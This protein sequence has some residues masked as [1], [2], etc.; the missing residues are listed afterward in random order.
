MI[1]LEW[2]K[3]RIEDDLPQEKS[4]DYLIQE[5][6]LLREEMTKSMDE[7]RLLERYSL[8]ATSVLW[9][10]AVSNMNNPPYKLVMWLPLLI[11]SLFSLR[12]LSLH[13]HTR[14]TGQYITMVEKQFSIPE[15]LGWHRYYRKEGDSFVALTGYFFWLSLILVTIIVPIVYG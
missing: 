6:R 9:T 13:R 1:K 5:V 3:D 8:L 7:A 10:W 4:L 14:F 15:S 12:V 11:T 2:H